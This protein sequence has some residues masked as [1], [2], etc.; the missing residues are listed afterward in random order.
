VN[1]Q[2]I[3]LKYY[4]EYGLLRFFAF[5]FSLFPNGLVV[6][7]GRRLGDLLWLFFPYRLKVMIINLGIVFPEWSRRQ[8]LKKAHEIYRF[9]GEV[10]ATYF[11]L[12]RKSMKQ[13]IL[14]TEDD[15]PDLFPDLLSEG[16]GIL[17][18][19]LHFGHWEALI[20]YWQM[21]NLPFSGIYKIQKNPLSHRYFDKRRLQ[22]G[23]TLQFLD[24]K[25]GI[26]AFVENIQSNRVV[27]NA[28][29]QSARSRG[30]EMPFFGEIVEVPRGNAKLKILSGAPLC[31][32]YHRYKNGRFFLHKKQITLPEMEEASDENIRHINTIL[33][34]EAEAAIRKYPEQWMWFHKLWKGKY[35]QPFKRKW[36]EYFL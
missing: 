30:I 34:Q 26:P 28:I 2:N 15:T 14:Q 12:H 29:D 18:A 36:H 19:T 13:K 27:V 9:F 10:S 33:L 17:Y 20:A 11:I 8:I 25:L 35:K 21:I 5:L 24:S 22:F 32:G 4:F 31:F 1:R 7:F 3:P 23:D 16:K 6:W